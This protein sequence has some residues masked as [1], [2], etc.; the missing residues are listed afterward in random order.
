[1]NRGRE[2]RWAWTLWRHSR[3]RDEALRRLQITR[4][5]ALVRH[6]HA[7]VPFYR[8]LYDRAG[9]VPENLRTIDDLVRLPVIG[10]DDV[11]ENLDRCRASDVDVTRCEL[12]STGGSTGAPLWIPTPR[13]QL[14]YEALGWLR[15]WRRLGLRIRDRQAAI[16]DLSEHSFAGERRWFQR[17]G[18][19]DIDYLSIYE[20]PEQLVHRLARSQPDVVRGRPSILES[21]AR[22]AEVMPEGR[23]IR[24]RRVFAT[25]EMLRPGARDRIERVFD[26]SVHDCYGATEAGCVAWCCPACGDYHVNADY[27]IVEV[28][29]D[30]RPAAPGQSGELVI[31]N[32]FARA[33]PFIRY[34]LGDQ[35]TVA[36]RN[37]CPFHRGAVSIERL[38]G[39][40]MDQ[41]VLADGRSVSPVWFTYDHLT[42]VQRFRVYHE[43]TGPDRDTIRV[44]IVPG[45]A[46]DRNLLE[47][48]RRRAQ[49][50]LGPRCT[51]TVELVHALDH[52]GDDEHR[53][54]ISRPGSDKPA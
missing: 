14:V 38:V 53:T 34:A 21:L 9:V 45:N 5:R 31:T 49:A 33:M 17:L 4:L 40:S 1:M 50:W 10:R 19:L 2:Y 30:G 35:C 12:R 52:V 36:A 24:P 8:D 27:V 37:D 29:H 3:L 11:R 6:A 13:E 42:G 18:L 46:L 48:E 41:I 51:L 28:L 43:R 44:S 25:S 54:V 23:H 32:L 20:P 16:K 26:T 22:V 15:T 39:R 47:E 7:V